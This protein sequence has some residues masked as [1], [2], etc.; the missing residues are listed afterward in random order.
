M[1]YFPVLKWRWWCLFSYFVSSSCCGKFSV[2]QCFPFDLAV[3]PGLFFLSFFKSP[4]L[5]ILGPRIFLMFCKGF[6]E[7][8]FQR[9]TSSLEI[10]KFVFG[11]GRGFFSKRALKEKKS[12]KCGSKRPL[13][14]AED[15]GGGRGRGVGECIEQNFQQFINRLKIHTRTEYHK[16]SK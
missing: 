14:L 11:R 13:F 10:D 1:Q 7:W 9:N 6:S 15:G 5:F 3:V 2:L 4:N 8:E 16:A 12:L